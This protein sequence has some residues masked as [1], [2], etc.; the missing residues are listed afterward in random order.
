MGRN[1][2]QL[3]EIAATA[4]NKAD[5][6]CKNIWAKIIFE[7]FEPEDT[8]NISYTTGSIEIFLEWRGQELFEN[9]IINIMESE[10]KIT[11][12]SFSIYKNE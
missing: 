5:C 6:A 4:I 8:P 7:G 3:F 10:G 1:L 2:K 11:P 12:D 9:T